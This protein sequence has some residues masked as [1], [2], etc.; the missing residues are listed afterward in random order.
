M[1]IER[2]RVSDLLSINPSLFDYY[3]N[4]N[5]SNEEKNQVLKQLENN[6]EFLLKIA[7]LFIH[8]EDYSSFISFGLIVDT[9]QKYFLNK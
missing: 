7:Q 2:N 9:L 5:L 4:E 8:K 3:L 6:E 1:S